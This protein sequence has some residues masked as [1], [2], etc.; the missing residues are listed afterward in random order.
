MDGFKR[1]T[2]I[3]GFA[4]VYR[5]Q[6]FFDVPVTVQYGAK[7]KL[8]GTNAG[9]RL[10][11]DG[12]V[13]AQ[14]RSRDISPGND[15]AGF[16]KWV[17]DNAEAWVLPVSAQTQEMLGDIIYFGEWAGK[18]IQKGDA[19]TKLDTKYFFV[20]A[21]Q[22]GDKF[23]TTPADIEM[24]IPDLDNVV[25]L[26]WDIIFEDP[27]D[28]SDVG[29]CEK[30]AEML[31]SRVKEVG[32][33]DPFIYGIFGVEGP[34]EG[35]VISPVCDPGTDPLE[36]VLDVYWYNCMT[37][38]VKVPDHNVKTGP[39]A[40]KDIVVPDGV[41]EFAEMFVT[42]A[43]CEQ[44]LWEEMG[45]VAIP[46]GTGRFLKWLNKDIIKESEVELEEAGL[47]WKDVQKHVVVAARAWYLTK[48]KE[49]S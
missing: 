20:F 34:G 6:Q 18:G 35:W 15:N 33:R 44:G 36:G 46:E 21:V 16:A 1:L 37:F 43:R 32:E 31:D 48:C 29:A 7:I 2:S 11:A 17:S 39:S 5:G 13:T 45:G 9:V 24:M 28:F 23:I 27:I 41:P 30:F 40:S 8:H 47:V 12:T 22:Y 10:S 25:V 42:D 14:S 49:L 19:V 26:P 38:K 4:H 3:E